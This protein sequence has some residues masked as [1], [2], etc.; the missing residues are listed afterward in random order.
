M[1]SKG[2]AFVIVLVAIALV[3][4]GVV[5]TSLTPSTELSSSSGPASLVQGASPFSFW[6]FR[7]KP[8]ATT[9]KKQDTS[10]RVLADIERQL[11][12]AQK[13]GGGISPTNYKS[14][15]ST[16]KT[17]EKKGVHTK[18]ARALL[19][20]LEVGGTRSTLKKDLGGQAKSDQNWNGADT[21]TAIEQ[22]IRTALKNGGRISPE[23]YREIDEKLKALEAKKVN[24][25]NARALYSSLLLGGKGEE[26]SSPGAENN[27]ENAGAV[28]WRF[29]HDKNKWVPQGVPPS[30]CPPLVF[31][32]PVDISKARA[33]LYPGQQR[34]LSIQ[35]YKAH[36]GFLF[37]TPDIEVRMPYDGYVM[38]G[39]R[40]LEGG[41][42]QYALDMISE[43][44]ILQRF[45]HLYTL[46]PK[47]QAIV[48]KFPEP[49]ENDSRT[50]PVRPMIQVKKGELIATQVGVPS[51][52]G[53]DWG[54]MDLRTEN[55]AAKDNAY[56]EKYAW[57]RGYAYHA[58]C[59]LDY[60]R[61]EDKAIAKAL[62]GGDGRMGKTSDYCGRPSS[63][64]VP[65][66]GL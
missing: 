46:T 43:C 36:G 5:L 63:S 12:L 50:T 29:E 54:V 20:K 55:E 47:F 41:Q 17:L 57:Q 64:T 27:F 10:A 6:S 26:T 14:I 45:G 24:T 44:G 52:P 9:A 7:E 32:S 56:R 8:A 37:S 3:G 31:D 33:I 23:S 59:W 53:M 49:K 35:D 65:V 11:G 19:Q 42:I 4:G 58:L 38:Q 16:L 18:R 15:E 28:W 51:N 2:S 60:L 22:S 48:E 66:S 25:T 61:E 30:S 62:P 39:A 34:G 21:L 1:Y 13:K 40:F